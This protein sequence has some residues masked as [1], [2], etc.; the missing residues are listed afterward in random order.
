MLKLKAEKAALKANKTAWLA[1]G[2]LEWW[3]ACC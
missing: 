1:A 3:T 2:L